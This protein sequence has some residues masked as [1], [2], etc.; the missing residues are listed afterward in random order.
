MTNRRPDA[1]VFFG[2]TGDLAK[3]KI[4][5]ALQ[6]MVRSGVAPKRVVC[7][8]RSDWS[9]E[10]LIGEAKSSIQGAGAV[11]AEAFAELSQRMQYV[12][13]DVTDLR[14]YQKMKTVLGGARRPLYY[15]ALPPRL[16]DETAVGLGAA[17]M[18]RDSRIVVE[19]PFG[20]D[21]ASARSLNAT[22]NQYFQPEAIF[23]IDH[24]LGKIAVQNLAFFRFANSF[25]AP[26]WNRKHVESVQITMAEKF[27]VADRG[28]FYDRTGAV[29]DVV[30]NHLIQV[31]AMLAM[32][33]PARIDAEA[34]CRAKTELLRAIEPVRKKD[35]VRGAFKGYRGV[36]GVAKDSDTE[37][38][39]ALRLRVKNWRWAGVPFLIRTGKRMA[40]TAT[41]VT[42][43]LRRP[44]IELFPEQAGSSSNYLRFRLYA[45]P[46]IAIGVLATSSGEE[47]T[48]EAVELFVCRHE[49]S[50]TD[51]YERILTDAIEG[52]QT[53]FASQE[54]V[55][56]AWKIF[57][58]ILAAKTPLHSYAPGSWGPE[59][60]KRLASSIG[61]WIDLSRSSGPNT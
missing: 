52:D 2:A 50:S 38:Y 15:L 31:V 11:D 41:E 53:L 47:I 39:V 51:A 8:G 40:A 16:V 59:E 13:L 43:K 9:R 1:F 19:K 44:P 4:F 17:E 29:R 28:G 45:E 35:I 33:P 42:V 46:S 21:L 54:G 48:M 22:L 60:A 34:L 49:S 5:P 10:K 12:A 18:T 14:E 61:G 30:Q 26:L 58:S 37:T 57:D 27:G 3:K 56:A 24:F 32:E 25:V 55:E 23:R 6:H 7:S 20:H 36:A